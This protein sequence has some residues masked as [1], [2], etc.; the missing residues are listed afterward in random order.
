MHWRGQGLLF[1]FALCEFHA[2][3]VVGV[4]VALRFGRRA[5]NN[6]DVV[7]FSRLL[8]TLVL[9]RSSGKLAGLLLVVV[10]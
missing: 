9:I 2:L 4:G 5:V 8:V 3:C 10:R 1:V 6:L 7:A